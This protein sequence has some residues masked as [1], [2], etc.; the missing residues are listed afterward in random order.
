MTAE[1]SVIIPS[2]NDY[3]DLSLATERDRGLEETVLRLENGSSSG[4]PEE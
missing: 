2:V 3:T 1:L 4:V